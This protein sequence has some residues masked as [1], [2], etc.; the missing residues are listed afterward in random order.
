MRY[1]PTCE[2]EYQDTVT[3][4]AEDGTPLVAR[5]TRREPPDDLTRL[6]KII[7]LADRFEA[8]ELAEQLADEGFD[9]ALVSDK[10][11]TVGPLTSPGPALYSV[12]VPDAKAETAR[13]LVAEWRTAMES[14]RAGAEAAADQEEQATEVPAAGV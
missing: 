8:E 3:V 14:D 2:G 7:T 1:C 12:V 5:A 13:A 6:T 9:V 10:A 11:S 4:C